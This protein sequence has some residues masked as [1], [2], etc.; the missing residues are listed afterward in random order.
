VTSQG[1]PRSTFKRAIERGN[2][3]VAEVTA[4][5]MGHIW[6]TDA[7]ALTVLAVETAPGKRNAYTTRVLRRLLDEDGPH[8][9]GRESVL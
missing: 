7:L 9:A 4:R 5:E 3:A 8:V 1:S 6:L 2:L